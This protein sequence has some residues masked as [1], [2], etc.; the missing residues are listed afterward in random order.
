[1]GPATPFILAAR[2]ALPY[3]AAALPSIINMFSSSGGRN[4]EEEIMKSIGPAAKKMSAETGISEEEATKALAGAIHEHVKNMGGQGSSSLETLANIAG[5]VVPGYLGYKAAKGALGA[6]KAATSAAKAASS[7]ASKAIVP[8]VENAIQL[9]SGQPRLGYDPS[10]GKIR[11]K[12]ML[13]EME[14][15]VTEPSYGV[16]E[17][18]RS[19]NVSDLHG[20]SDLGFAANMIGDPTNRQAY[21]QMIGDI[22]DREFARHL[23]DKIRAQ[24]ASRMSRY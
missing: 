24:Y 8:E 16:V 10:G 14:Q 18:Y 20:P 7:S 12:S 6:T 22:T 4:N 11:P 15:E 2:A 21:S 1:M 13:M 9:P 3:A 17:R 19:P 23:N 5:I